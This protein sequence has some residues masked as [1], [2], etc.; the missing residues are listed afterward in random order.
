[1]GLVRI[2]PNTNPSTTWQEARTRALRLYREWLAEVPRSINKY[3]LDISVAAGRALV[4]R[5]FDRQAAQLA[6]VH[7]PEIKLKLLNNLVLKGTMI[8]IDVHNKYAQKLHIM[9]FFDEDKRI[10]GDISQ[11]IPYDMSIFYDRDKEKKDYLL[12]EGD[13]K[14]RDI[15]T[16]QTKSR[17]SGPSEFLVKFLAG[18]PLPIHSPNNPQFH[19][20][21]A[22]AQDIVSVEEDKE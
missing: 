21:E 17:K 6:Q 10:G 4:R 19:F 2:F 8:L 1:M 20:T 15:V 16:T 3:P 13:E 22:Q 9:R 5:Y 11:W 7:D 18:E 12:R 14:Q